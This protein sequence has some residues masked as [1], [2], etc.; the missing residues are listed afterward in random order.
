MKDFG[1]HTENPKPRRVS[2]RKELAVVTLAMVAS[3]SGV[4]GLL[5]GSQQGNSQAAGASERPTVAA[6]AS[7]SGT[8]D[9]LGMVANASQPGDDDAGGHA[10]LRADK[11]K[12]TPNSTPSW[13]ANSQRPAAAVSQGSPPLR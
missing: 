1:S 6:P 12:H 9:R 2:H 10:V 7:P 13:S 11:G 5:A 4:G 8:G 3:I